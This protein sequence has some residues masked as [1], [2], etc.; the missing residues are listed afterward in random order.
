MI[1]K[2]PLNEKQPYIWGHPQLQVSIFCQSEHLS[3]FL[4]ETCSN[5][6]KETTP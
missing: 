2:I 5:I 1:Y 6:I 4:S 3:L